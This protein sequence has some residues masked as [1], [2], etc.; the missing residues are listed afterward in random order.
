MNHEKSICN[1]CRS[2]FFIQIRLKLLQYNEMIQITKKQLRKTGLEGIQ[3]NCCF[4]KGWQFFKVI[5]NT[6]AN[7]S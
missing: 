7:E 6:V 2:M 5:M 4:V 1:R 3:S